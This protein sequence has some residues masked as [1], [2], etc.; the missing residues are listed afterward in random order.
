M[1]IY[2][3][4]IHN[5]S[6][7]KDNWIPY[8][9][10]NDSNVGYWMQ[11][12]AYECVLDG[13]NEATLF[14]N[15]LMMSDSSHFIS[16]KL[17]ENYNEE[18]VI[19]QLELIVEYLKKHDTVI[20]KELNGWNI[21]EKFDPFGESAVYVDPDG[22]VYYHPDSYYAGEK[23]LCHISEYKEDF[24]YT[25]PHLICLNCNTF[26]CHRNVQLNKTYTSEYKAPCSF[27][28]K[29]TT[30]FAKYSKQ[31]FNSLAGETMLKEE[32]LDL[33]DTFDAE[34]AYKKFIAG[35]LYNHIKNADYSER[36]L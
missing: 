24:H 5:P 33:V 14:R 13:S 29:E 16:I 8:I 3:E 2:Y 36:M 10:I 15:F 28:C 23:P 17:R 6:L 27:Q 25:R 11:K 18:C 9:V 7:I 26:Y 35:N 4:T 21:Q 19:E 12:S 30:L 31:L 20:V 22:M 34:I 1:K 32:P